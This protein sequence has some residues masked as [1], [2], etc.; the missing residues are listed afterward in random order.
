MATQSYYMGIPKWQRQL[1]SWPRIRRFMLFDSIVRGFPTPSVIG[2][3]EGDHITIID[4]LQRLSTIR[5]IA[6]D[7]LRMPTES[8][9]VS[10]DPTNIQ[11]I[12]SRKKLSQLDSFWQ[13]RFWQ[14]QLHFFIIDEGVPES[15]IRD[16][17][18]RLQWGRPLYA[19]EIQK[20][21]LS[22]AIDVVEAVVKHPFWFDIYNGSTR[23]EERFQMAATLLAMNMDP[24]PA[25][26]IPE[27]VN[28]ILGGRADHRLP[29]DIEGT[30]IT[31]LS[32]MHRLFFGAEM[33]GR[34]DIV[35]MTMAV[36][37]LRRSDG[38]VNLEYVA[39]GILAPW[40]NRVKKQA[41]NVRGKDSS[42]TRLSHADEQQ[43]FWQREQGVML[44]T[45]GIRNFS[46]AVP[47]SLTLT[48]Y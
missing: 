5:Q 26:L 7:G 29:E 28:L 27:R 20:T 23:H 24:W 18:R 48:N 32:Q 6:K 13:K 43:A 8:E 41:I 10:Q 35:P 17:F 36:Q 2:Q 12:E 19:G 44:N 1:E 47:S 38:I 33:K 37:T 40:F 25:S 45:P 31:Q 9:F 4:G 39:Q 11:P 30:L 46:I 16:I 14:Y 22:K 21:F 42:F 34:I 3:R 15:I